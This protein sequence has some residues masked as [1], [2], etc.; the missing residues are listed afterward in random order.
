[1]RFTMAT[2]RA[3]AAAFCSAASSPHP[4]NRAQIAKA[5]AILAIIFAHKKLLDILMG[6]PDE[7][8]AASIAPSPR[9]SYPCTTITQ[10][11]GGSSKSKSVDVNARYGWEAAAQRDTVET[12]TQWRPALVLKQILVSLS[13]FLTSHVPAQA[14]TLL[15]YEAHKEGRAQ[16]IARSGV[17]IDGIVIQGFNARKHKPEIIKATKVYIGDKEG[18]PS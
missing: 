16:R 18:E 6:K 7:V 15:N 17:V 12:V 4:A 14:C 5:T 8:A 10:R 2:S 1:M 9:S 11:T 3:S 13:I